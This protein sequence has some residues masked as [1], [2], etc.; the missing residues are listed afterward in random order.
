[1]RIV[2]LSDVHVWRYVLDPRHLLNK[3]AVGVLG[4][5]VSRARKFRLERLRDVVERVRGLE[6]DHVLITGDL[7]TTSHASEFLAAREALADL[8]IDAERATVIPG[9]HDRYTIGAVRSRAFEEWFGAFAP[10]GAYPWLR[11]LDAETAILGLDPTRAHIGPTG[12]LPPSQASAARRILED[13]TRR[14][15][16]LIVACHYPIVA[17]MA[18]VAELRRKRLTNAHTVAALLE[19]AGRHLFCCGHVH[20]AWAFRPSTIPDQLCLN[21]GAPLL[22]D[23]TGVRPPGFLEITLH[24][25]DVSV[26]HHAWVGHDWETRALH[27]DPSFFD[28]APDLTRRSPAVVDPG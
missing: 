1:V 18:H 27:Q 5:A 12:W 23:R 24:D 16:R 13:A 2:H 26:V 7:T 9:N 8:L 14:P 25:R 19:G 15:R 28:A 21:A 3:R 22:R 20:A 11:W 17:P 10:A 6:P 4:L